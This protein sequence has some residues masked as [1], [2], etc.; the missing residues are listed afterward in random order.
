MIQ[1]SKLLGLP[2]L[3]IALMIGPPACFPQAHVQAA[4]SSSAPASQIVPP[5]PS[6]HFPHGERFVYSVEWHMFNAGTATILLQHSPTGEHLI[7]TADS[8]GMVNTM[9]PVHD[10]FQADIDPR[11]FCT[12][13]IS[14]H[15]EEGSRRLDRK[16]RFDYSQSKSQVD[17]HDLKTGDLKHTEFDIPSCVTDVVSGF[18]YASSLRL[19]PGLSQVFPVNDRGKTTDVRIEVESRE[20]VKVPS[21]EF[22]TL[23]VKAEPLSGAMKAKG[24]LWVW[25]S[26]DERRVPVQ[27]KSKLGYGTLLFRLQR[28]EMQPT[29]QQ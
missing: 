6:Y 23:R 17:E 29:G 11:T 9:F 2:L 8:A 24:V 7:S 15:A 10:V 16:V 28:I 18:F 27:M 25:F 14:K 5:P 4:P 1:R 20:R 22:E 21:G 19:Q 3:L 26:D 12:S 13:E